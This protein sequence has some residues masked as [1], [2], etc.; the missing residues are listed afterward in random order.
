MDVGIPPQDPVREGLVQIGGIIRGLG[1]LRRLTCKLSLFNSQ[2][3]QREAD[4]HQNREGCAI[5]S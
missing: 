5:E 1:G 4:D 3:G 2:C